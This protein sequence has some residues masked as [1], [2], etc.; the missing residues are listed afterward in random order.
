MEVDY[1]TATFTSEGSE[2][3]REV[4]WGIQSLNSYCDLEK[5]DVSLQK[6][7]YP[8]SVKN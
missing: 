2:L 6:S 8:F 1:L 4:D 7:L 5:R 3:S